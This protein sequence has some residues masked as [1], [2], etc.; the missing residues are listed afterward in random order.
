MNKG[1]G[2]GGDSEKNGDDEGGDN[3]NKGNGDGGDSKNNG[4]GEGG[5][6]KN[7]GDVEGGDSKNNGDGFA[8]NTLLHTHTHAQTYVNVHALHHPRSGSRKSPPLC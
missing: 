3:E 4:D 6:S 2:N 8:R 7:N 1:D 5:E